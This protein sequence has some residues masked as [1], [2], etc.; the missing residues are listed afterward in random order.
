MD[1]RLQHLRGGDHR[2][3]HSDTTTDDLLLEMWKFGN[4]EFGAQITPG[5]HD[6]TGG[7]D[8]LI[9]VLDR[10]A[11]LDLGDDLRAGRIGLELDRPTER[12]SALE[13]T[14]IVCRADEGQRHHVDL[15][16]DEGRED[17][18]ISCGRGAELRAVRGDV[19]TRATSESTTMH[20]LHLDPVIAPT[21][22]SHLN[23]PVAEGEE[24][25]FHD[26]GEEGGMVNLYD[27]RGAG[28]VAGDERQPR[29]LDHGDP[30]GVD[31]ANTDLWTG[32]ID[33]DPHWSALTSRDVA[34][35]V[36]SI[37]PVLDAAMREVDPCDV[38]AGVDKRCEG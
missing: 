17:L 35:S 18:Q 27:D 6:S 30:L 5:D 16:G 2:P 7:L 29:P 33:E 8:D 31:L 32:Q 20:H 28:V 38:H 13:T 10:G 1:H 4:G 26:V 22:G 9:E 19:E 15:D 23:S 37:E 21:E 34:D 12:R 11:G 24:I 25:S 14:K 36:E 3:P